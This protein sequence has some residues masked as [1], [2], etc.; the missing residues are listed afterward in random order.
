MP[1]VSQEATAH[2]PSTCDLFQVT[3]GESPC[4]PAVQQPEKAG[5]LLTPE[6]LVAI[7]QR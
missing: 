1:A 6:A 5:A 2:I 7:W 4:V 3:T